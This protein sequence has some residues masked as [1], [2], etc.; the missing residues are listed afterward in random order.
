MHLNNIVIAPLL[1]GA[2]FALLRQ[3]PLAD[4]GISQDVTYSMARFLDTLIVCF[5]SRILCFLHQKANDC[6]S[7]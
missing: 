6:A 5:A 2:A 4:E 7:F 3:M 1:A